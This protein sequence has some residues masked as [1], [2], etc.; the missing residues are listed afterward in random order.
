MEIRC[1]QCRKKLG[2]RVLGLYITDC[3]RCHSP[4][5]VI[6]RGSETVSFRGERFLI[7]CQP[8]TAPEPGML[9]ATG[10]YSPPTGVNAE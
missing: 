7:S 6:M 9:T 1:P 3:P 4:V 10:V 8:A 2:N 5:R